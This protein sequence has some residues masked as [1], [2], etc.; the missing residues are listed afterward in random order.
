MVPVACGLDSGLFRFPPFFSGPD[1]VRRSGFGHCFGLY[2]AVELARLDFL[3]RRPV[4]FGAKLVA[5]T[6]PDLVFCRITDYFTPG[7]T[8]EKRHPA[9][10][11][12]R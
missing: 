1:T 9:D 2:A 3:P 12:D 10:G 11:F 5:A 6:R 7:R 4:P 8:P